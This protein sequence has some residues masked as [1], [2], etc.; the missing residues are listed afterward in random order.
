M[1]A[2]GAHRDD[3]WVQRAAAGL[4]VFARR[5][6]ECRQVGAL[7]G[8]PPAAAAL[9]LSELAQRFGVGSGEVCIELAAFVDRIRAR[10]AARRKV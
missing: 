5:T 9:L 2:K 7:L 1:M 4:S 6:P 3:P 8:I 10:A